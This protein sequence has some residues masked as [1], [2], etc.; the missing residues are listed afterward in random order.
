MQCA[1][2]GIEK[3]N[4]LADLIMK[5]PDQLCAETKTDAC[6]VDILCPLQIE[7]HDYGVHVYAVAMRVKHS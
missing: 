5:T 2:S 1:R 4:F 6:R 3:F 7:L